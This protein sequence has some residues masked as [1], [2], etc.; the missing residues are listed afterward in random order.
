[1]PSFRN[2]FSDLK[3]AIRAFDSSTFGGTSVAA[4]NKEIGGAFDAEDA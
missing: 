4:R 2:K 3:K 1:M